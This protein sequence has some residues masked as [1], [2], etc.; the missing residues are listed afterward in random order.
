MIGTRNFLQLSK[1]TLNVAL[2]ICS[3]FSQ[4]SRA[5]S[6]TDTDA[7]RC[8]DA[9]VEQ[10]GRHFH[11]TDFS[12]PTNRTAQDA[13]RGGRVIAGVCRNW[14]GNIGRVIV[15]F[16]YDAEVEYEKKLLVAV[17][18]SATHRVI[19]AYQDVI[20]EDAATQVSSSSLTLDLAPYKLSATTRAFG[21][22][23]NTFQD[24]CS[25]EGGFDNELTLFVV[26]GKALRPVLSETIS[27][28]RNARGN[29]CGGEEVERV[30]S[31]VVISVEPRSTQ[32]FAD[33][34]FTAK[35]S[36]KRKPVQAVVKY[37][38]SRYDLQPWRT[39]FDP[40][41]EAT[42]VEPALALL[43]SDAISAGD[44]EQARNIIA[45]GID[46]NANGNRNSTPLQEAASLGKKDMVNFL[47]DRG[48]DVNGHARMGETALGTAAEYGLQD[49]AELLLARGA[50]I[51]GSGY[52]G[53]TPL[54]KAA[55]SK[56]SKMV[57][58]LL[59]KGA[60]VNLSSSGTTPFHL[61][62]MSGDKEI[63][64][65]IIAKG[66]DVRARDA[67]G[68]TPLHMAAYCGSR[69]GLELLITLHVD[70]EA[71]DQNLSTPLHWAARGGCT[72]AV[73]L[74]LKYGADASAINGERETPLQLANKQEKAEVV[75]L[76]SAPGVMGSAAVHASRRAKT[77]QL[78]EAART[79]RL[80]EV[81]ALLSQ[82]VPIDAKELGRTLLYQSAFGNK[83]MVVWL[84]AKG[85]DPNLIVSGGWMPL[86][87]AVHE[88]R[89][90]LV[91]ILLSKGAAVS[92]RG[93]D[94]LT[95]LH[96]ALAKRNEDIAK[97]LIA[98]GAEVNAKDVKWNT[99]LHFAASS[100][101][102]PM[103]KLLLANK[104]D[105]KARDVEGSTPLHVAI[106]TSNMDVVKLLLESGSD[107]DALNEMGTVLHVAAYK[108]AAFQES[109]DMVN[110][111]I[112]KGVGI[113][114]KNAAGVTVLQS[115]SSDQRALINILK[116]HGAK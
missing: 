109:L 101:Q 51:N 107:I 25:F 4:C 48:A 58:L 32:G 6:Q 99:P 103:V 80:A 28:W 106:S 75:R 116:A 47:I 87:I 33:L 29:R 78:F 23:V 18:D 105:V 108:V 55:T 93:D 20:G 54:H 104:A 22:R 49:I 12:Y 7:H 95:P 102:L 9:I 44:I 98:K 43:L 77:T 62:A 63:M 3:G 35:P 52:V 56:Q 2:L 79:Q 10:V 72:E 81:Q 83:D 46:L 65:M 113:N 34:R 114:V 96:I 89:L 111:L 17:L 112:I 84:L 73:E 11:L 90:D 16:A 70:V 59:A 38:G 40:W 88:G 41:W 61:A 24:R 64:E 115:T 66:A 8:A 53:W 14:P 30:E 36:D 42:V 39:V 94:G 57:A 100:G 86:H 1:T 110:F 31:N 76:L 74:L 85:A 26:T 27:R 91:E 67:G 15:A 13:E 71:Q 97:H 82:G 92:A 50:D 60:D 37:N 19:A 5:Q 45:K 21:L 69:A 68:R